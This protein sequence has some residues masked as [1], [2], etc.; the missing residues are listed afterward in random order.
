LRA[1]T[2][3]ADGGYIMNTKI[4]FT[5]TM[6]YDLGEQNCGFEQEKDFIVVGEGYTFSDWLQDH[7]VR[8]N[9]DDDI[10]FILDNDLSTETR[11]GEAYN[12]INQESTDMELQ[13]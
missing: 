8:F 4:T 1:V 3:E 12:V 11:T 2:A 9:Q 5:H 6:N 10:Y 7:N 13:G